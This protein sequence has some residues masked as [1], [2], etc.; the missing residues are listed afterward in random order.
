MARHE[1]AFGSPEASRKASRMVRKRGFEPP[2]YCYRQPLKLVRLP[3]PPLPRVVRIAASIVSLRRFCRRLLGAGVRS[4]GAGAVEPA[5]SPAPESSP[6]PAS[7]RR[8]RGRRRRRRP[9]PACRS[10][11]SRAPRWPMIASASAPSMN[12]TASTA[13]AFVSTRRAARARR[14]PSGCCRR[15]TRSPCRRPCPAAAGSPAAA[16]GRRARKESSSR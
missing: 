14:T 5:S 2:R 1:R 4:R 3:V 13:V 15:R 11:P 6:A 12:S 10:R 8:R 9:A 7:V 16:R